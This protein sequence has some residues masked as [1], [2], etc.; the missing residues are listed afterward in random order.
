MSS[1]CQFRRRLGSAAFSLVEVVLALGVMSFALTGIVGLLPVG[2]SHFRKAMDQTIQ[3]QIAQEVTYMVQRTPFQ[4][5]DSLGSESNPTVT[6]Y[7]QEGTPVSQKE[8]V[9]TVS[10]SAVSDSGLNGLLAPTWSL[11]SNTGKALN[12]VKAVKISITN[13][14]FPN[15]SQTITTYV[16]NAGL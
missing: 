14:T 11:D 5:I 3:S 1:P 4:N 10:T 13:R 6:Y 15:Y 8:S 16:A 9:Y 12:N 7:D 2:L